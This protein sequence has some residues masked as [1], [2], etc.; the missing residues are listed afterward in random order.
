MENLKQHVKKP[1]ICLISKRAMDVSPYIRILK[2]HR[3]K[4]DT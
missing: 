3:T 4:L 1:E 2:I